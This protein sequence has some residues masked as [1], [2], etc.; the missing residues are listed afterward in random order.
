MKYLKI[1][2]LN[3]AF[4]IIS[5]PMFSQVKRLAPPK[6][7]SRI[8][9]VDAFVDNTFLL[10]HKIFVYDSL[11]KANV[12]VPSEFEDELLSSMEKDVDSMWT[13]LPNI[14]EDMEGKGSFLKKAKAVV[15]LNRAKKALKFCMKA[16]KNHLVGTKEEE[17]EN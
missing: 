7:S 11:S 1:L 6:K 15:N 16:S 14:L 12:E 2:I 10:Y 3:I 9:S 13:I 4:L 8:T 17:E 5:A